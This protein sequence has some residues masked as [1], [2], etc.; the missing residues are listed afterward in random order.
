MI[1]T[2]VTITTKQFSWVLLPFYHSWWTI[3][4]VWLLWRLGV[5]YWALIMSIY[6]DRKGLFPPCKWWLVKQFWVSANHESVFKVTYSNDTVQN[7]LNSSLN[8]AWC[9]AYLAVFGPLSQWWG[10]QLFSMCERCE[11]V[12]TKTVLMVKLTATV[13]HFRHLCSV[14][15]IKK[16]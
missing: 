6:F 16:A 4:L 5:L 1:P 2:T 12:S 3:W 13:S 9:L 8:Y 11:W 14:Y 15:A 10:L 7:M